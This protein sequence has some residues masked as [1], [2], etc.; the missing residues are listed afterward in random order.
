VLPGCNIRSGDGHTAPYLNLACFSVPPAGSFGN[1]SVSVF[2]LPGSYNV[3][4]SLYKYFKLY[5][6]S[7]KLRINAVAHNVFN[8]VEWGGV[9]NNISSP[10]SFGQLTFGGG[11][12]GMRSISGQA[13]IQW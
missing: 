10:A 9:N 4:G 13:Q 12:S 6:E 1:S 2:H 11:Y 3:D 7:V 5:R 8:H